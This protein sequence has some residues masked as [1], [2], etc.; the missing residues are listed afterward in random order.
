MKRTDDTSEDVK[1][2]S[3]CG[4]PLNSNN[5]TG[6]HTRCAQPAKKC[7]VCNKPLRSD[8]PGDTHARCVKGKAAR[9]ITRSQTPPP[10]KTAAKP[11]AGV[12]MICVTEANLDNFWAKLSLDEKAAIFARQLEGA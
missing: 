2:C 5:T 11:A 3:V 9:A 8:S 12:A 10:R 7:S 1:L 6:V 4:E